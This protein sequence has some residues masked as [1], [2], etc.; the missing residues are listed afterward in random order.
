MVVAV[1]KAKFISYDE[2]LCIKRR[3]ILHKSKKLN[4]DLSSPNIGL[5]QKYHKSKFKIYV[6]C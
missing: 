2:E 1:L 3:E 6:D 4:K 5:N